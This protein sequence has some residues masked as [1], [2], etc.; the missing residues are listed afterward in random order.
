LDIFVE[1]RCFGRL[2]GSESYFECYN[3]DGTVLTLQ[4]KI[5]G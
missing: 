1:I 3:N 5:W 2:V 4:I